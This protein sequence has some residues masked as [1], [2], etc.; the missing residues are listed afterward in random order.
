MFTYKGTL[1]VQWRPMDRH[2]P[3]GPRGKMVCTLEGSQ[4]VLHLFGVL[5]E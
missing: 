2:N 3:S 5:L 1:P 4:T